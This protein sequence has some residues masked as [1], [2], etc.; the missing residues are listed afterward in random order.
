AR[1]ASRL[2]HLV[3]ASSSSVYGDRHDGPFREDDRCDAPASLYGATKRGGELM[4][5][6]YARL[7]GLKQT[8]L[9]FFTVYGP[10]GRPDMAYWSFTDAVLAGKPIALF[11]EG[12]LARDFTYIDD[13]APAIERLLD[14]PPTDAPPHRILNLGNSHPSTVLDLVAAV[15][16]ATG[17]SAIRE[18]LPPQKGDVTNTFAD[19]SRAKALV[20]FEPSTP[21]DVGIARFVEW[22]RAHSSF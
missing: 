18:L 14:K 5:E 7:F 10:W 8:G 17:K 12:K 21:L 1:K 16:R 4:S 2:E 11:G 6:S 3:Y 22:R 13:M 15:E 19:I 20:G 9:R